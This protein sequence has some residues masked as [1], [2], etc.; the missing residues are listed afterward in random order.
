MSDT[1]LHV[2]DRLI[3]EVCEPDASSCERLLEHL[4]SARTYLL[5]Q[6]PD[7]YIFSLGLANESLNC[8]PNKEQRDR[9]SESIH[10]LIETGD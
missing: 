3:N 1:D 7:E 2:L 5:G 9:A 6:M 8:L 4:E 10:H